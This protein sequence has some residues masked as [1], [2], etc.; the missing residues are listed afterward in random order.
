[1]QKFKLHTIESAPDGSKQILQAA[2][3][4]MGMI[5]NLFAVMAT[6]PQLLEGYQTLDGLFQK[7]GFD[8]NEL[9]VVWQ[10]INVYHDC[11]YCV[12]AHTAIAKQMGAD[13]AITTQ[14]KAGESLDDDKLQALR[15][16]TERMLDAR[17][18]VNQDDFKAFAEAGYEPKHVLAVI[19]GI[20]QKTMSNYTNHVAETP[21]DNAFQDFA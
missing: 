21:I 1:M 20:A 2:Q 9:T 19:L 8:K 7:S 12:P 5:P 15:T 4:N 3:D 17:G 13:D 14:I 10:T 11:H 16:F 6:S 18:A